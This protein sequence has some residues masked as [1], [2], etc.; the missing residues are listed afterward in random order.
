MQGKSQ[1]SF[2]KILE[3]KWYH[4]NVPLMRVHLKGQIIGFH[5]NAKVQESA[6]HVSTIDSGVKRLSVSAEIHCKVRFRVEN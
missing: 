5:L 4:V 2:W 6:I 1:I 3:N